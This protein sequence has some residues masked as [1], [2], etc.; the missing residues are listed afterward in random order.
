MSTAMKCMVAACSLG[1]ALSVQAADW[2]VGASVG[3]SDFKEDIGAVP[4]GVTVDTRDTG[5]KLLLGASLTP[6]FAVEGGYVDVGKLK[7]SGGGLSAGIKANGYFVDLLGRMP[8]STDVALLARIG[9]FNGH[10]KTYGFPALG[11]GPDQKDS[12]TDVKF[13]VGV[14]YAV[15]K[16]TAVRAEWERYRFKFQGDKGDVDLLSVGMI[17]SF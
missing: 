1:A 16:S 15:N 12:S 17:F 8:V 10:A 14:S 6:N 7:V 4:A 3:A 13:G 9:V 2:Y 11:A 5:F